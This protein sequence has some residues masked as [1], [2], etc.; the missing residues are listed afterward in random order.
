MCVRVQS[1]VC[2]LHISFIEKSNLFSLL[3]F[4]QTLHF[5][6]LKSSSKNLLLLSW[7]CGCVIVGMCVCE[8]DVCQPLLLLIDF[9]IID[10]VREL[11][12]ILFYELCFVFV[13]DFNE[14]N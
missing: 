7:H 2:V 10:S 3:L 12:C 11:F 13:R 6:L 1:V 9:K 5:S 14:E 4:M 8:W